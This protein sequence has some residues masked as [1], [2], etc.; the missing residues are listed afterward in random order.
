MRFKVQ[1]SVVITC[2]HGVVKKIGKN[3][4]MMCGVQNAVC[5]FDVRSTSKA[6]AGCKLKTAHLPFSTVDV[7]MKCVDMEVLEK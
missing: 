6:Q 3:E 1:H 4:R 5:V 2:D 7:E